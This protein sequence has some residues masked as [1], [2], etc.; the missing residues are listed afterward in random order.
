MITFGIKMRKRLRI[1]N[2]TRYIITCLFHIFCKI[3]NSEPAYR[4]TVHVKLI[5]DLPAA[6]RSETPDFITPDPWP[7]NSPDINP[8][9]YR[10]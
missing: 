4:L 10:I 3:R 1:L 5:I 2:N 8:V 9:H 6:T 7:P